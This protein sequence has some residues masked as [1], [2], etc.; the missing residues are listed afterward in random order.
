MSQVKERHEINE[1]Y[2][3]D[4]SALF[5]SDEA[6]EEG[7]S[8]LKQALPALQRFRGKLHEKETLLQYFRESHDTELLS[9]RLFVYAKMKRDLDNSDAQSVSMVDR[10]LSF[11]TQAE[12][13]IA[14]VTPELT[15]LPDETLLAWS[16][17]AA[18]ADHSLTLSE[19]VR[20][21]QHILSE[22]EERLLA[23][24]G[25]MAS[26]PQNTFTMLNNVDLTFTPIT[27]PD[28]T[29]TELSHGRYGLFLENRD[30]SVR[31]QAYES[32][33]GAIRAHIN[34]LASLY[35]ANVKKDVFY[36]RIRGFSGA[37]EAAL[38]GGNIP[39]VVYDG[40]IEAVHG[41]F[42]ALHRYI[43]R[44]KDVLGVD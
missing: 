24:S 17:D 6:W 33:Y 2:R 34:T 1:R 39:Q 5:P 10:A 27:L 36:A 21:K 42:P 32:M 8:S 40:L 7:F 31:K 12:A 9:E 43:A 23:L 4:L 14:F 20:E 18:F 19:I 41:A 22:K 26:A 38:F 16:R 29:K 11:L 15:A 3:W 37:R 25:E 28:G 13:E 30:R 44:R 35:A